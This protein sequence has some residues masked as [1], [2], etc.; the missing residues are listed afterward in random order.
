[1][2]V[3]LLITVTRDELKLLENHSPH[4]VLTHG[5]W[6]RQPL[7]PSCPP[8]TLSSDLGEGKVAGNGKSEVLKVLED[9]AECRRPKERRKKKKREEQPEP[10]KLVPSCL[11]CQWRETTWTA[12]LSHFSTLWQ[13]TN[14]AGLCKQAERHTH[15]LFS[16]ILYKPT[17]APP[18]L[19][20][21]KLNY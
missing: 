8:I 15:T 1:M 7:P 18:G 11:T 16:P 4:S 2:L 17:V 21:L 9:S 6:A 13:P 10:T 14:P 19:M 12:P 3:T 20:L 5:A